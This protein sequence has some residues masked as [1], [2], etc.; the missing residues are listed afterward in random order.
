M[1]CPFHGRRNTVVINPAPD[2]PFACPKHG[3][4]FADFEGITPAYRS[5]IATL[6]TLAI[7]AEN[8]DRGDFFYEV[9]HSLH[10]L[11]MQNAKLQALVP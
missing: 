8:P 10:H 11:A 1:R 2:A 4:P 9:A 7:E 5:A 3:D 6:R